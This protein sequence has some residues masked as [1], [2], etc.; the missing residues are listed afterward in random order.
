MPQA[1]KETRDQVAKIIGS[2]SPV[3]DIADVLNWLELNSTSL[4]NGTYDSLDSSNRRWSLSDHRRYR[5]S[6]STQKLASMTNLL[7]RKQEFFTRAYLGLASQ[8]FEQS[9]GEVSCLYRGPGGRKC[10]IGWSITDEQYTRRMDENAG[11]DC[12]GITRLGENLG[13]FEGLDDHHAGQ[14]SE[15]LRKLQHVH[16]SNLEP[17]A[18]QKTLE[19]LARNENHVVPTIE[20]KQND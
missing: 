17:D 13:W 11:L 4:G 12:W 1:S 8:G 18:M 6:H 9:M 7:E 14:L 2:D 20:E 16:D 5:H 3:P 10:A 19:R 15:F